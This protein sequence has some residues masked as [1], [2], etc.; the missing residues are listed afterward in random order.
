M[1][2]TLVFYE[3]YARTFVLQHMDEEKDFAGDL[4]Y[5]R[6]VTERIDVLFFLSSSSTWTGFQA[7]VVL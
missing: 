7:T 6:M 2:Y 1:V 3:K 5:G 4:N